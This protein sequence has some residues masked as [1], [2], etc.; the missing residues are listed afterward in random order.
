MNTIHNNVRDESYRS[1]RNLRQTARRYI[2][3]MINS[4]V[5]LQQSTGQ[6][7]KAGTASNPGSGWTAE[8]DARR[9]EMISPSLT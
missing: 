7:T 9:L 5:I 1:S 3:E 2:N 6:N 8:L 4:V